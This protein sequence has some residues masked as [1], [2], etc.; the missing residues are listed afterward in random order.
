M[1]PMNVLWMHHFTLE[2]FTDSQRIWDKYLTESPRLMFQ[3]IVHVAR[4]NQNA[5]LIIKLIDQLRT[6]KVTEGALGNV[7]SCLLDV[8]TLKQQYDEGLEALK[9]SIKDVC[10]EHINRTALQR[11]KDG[12]EKSGKEFPYQIPARTNVKYD[13]TTT[14]SSGSSSSSDDEPDSKKKQQTA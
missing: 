4:E 6:A 9:T 11:L 3:R 14:S 8:Y 10:L 1:A 13:D 5:G 2:N 7:Y 12:L